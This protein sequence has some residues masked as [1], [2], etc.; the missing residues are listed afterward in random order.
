MPEGMEGLEAGGLL[1]RDEDL[2]WRITA[3]GP[4]LELEC[5]TL[6]SLNPHGFRYVSISAFL[7]LCVVCM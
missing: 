2:H 5:W 3:G 1:R 6:D 4:V 7:E